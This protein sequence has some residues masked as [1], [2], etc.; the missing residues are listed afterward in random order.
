MSSHNSK[1]YR[2]SLKTNPVRSKH[3][4]QVFEVKKSWAIGD[5]QENLN[6]VES[7]VSTVSINILCLKVSSWRDNVNVKKNY[8]NHWQLLTLERKSCFISFNSIF[9]FV[10]E[11]NADC[12]FC[13]LRRIARERC[14]WVNGDEEEISSAKMQKMHLTDHRKSKEKY[15]DAFPDFYFS[16]IELGWY[17]KVCSSFAQ[18]IACSISSY[19][20]FDNHPNQTVLRHLSSKRH[21]N[22]SKNKLAYED[23]SERHD[24]VWSMMRN[25]SLASEVHP[26]RRQTALFSRVFFVSLGCW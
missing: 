7:D 10:H 5:E 2:E 12:K 22:A 14:P 16:N 9:V 18:G 6:I 19:I 26:K 13:L 8:S 20:D 17:C 25:A 1:Y 4:S 15:E 23:L 21:Q 11:G 3:L 24:N